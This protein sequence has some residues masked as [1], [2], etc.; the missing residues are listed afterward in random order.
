MLFEVCESNCVCSSRSRQMVRSSR[1]E[2]D[3][4]TSFAREASSLQ[5]R[6]PLLACDL[7]SGLEV[8]TKAWQAYNEAHPFK[9]PALQA[10]LVVLMK[11]LSRRLSFDTNTCIPR[12]CTDKTFQMSEARTLFRRKKRTPR[13]RVTP[14]GNLPQ[15]YKTL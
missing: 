15:G 8:L 2:E 6:S 12:G 3:E 4:L 1:P 13:K 9:E 7:E 11:L 10:A 5:C 14:N